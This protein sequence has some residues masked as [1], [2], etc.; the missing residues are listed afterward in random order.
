[1]SFPCGSADGESA[2]NSG[3]LR[4]I[5]GLRRFPGEGKGYPF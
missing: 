3:D 4:S 1:M 2:C 5:T